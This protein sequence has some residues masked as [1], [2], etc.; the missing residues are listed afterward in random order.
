MGYGMPF[1]SARYV[2]YAL[3]VCVVAVFYTASCCSHRPCYNE[4]TWCR[5]VE[6]SSLTGY[7]S[8]SVTLNSEAHE[9]IT[10]SICYR[11]T[12]FNWWYENPLQTS[13]FKHFDSSFPVKTQKVETLI[14]WHMVDSWL[15]YSGLMKNGVCRSSPHPTPTLHT[16]IHCFKP[17]ICCSRSPWRPRQHVLLVW[18]CLSNHL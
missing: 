2:I 16:Q 10:L 9:I 13:F 3:Y 15:A 12:Y 11:G 17:D 1:M 8:F 7:P 6:Y 5:N 4:T 14:R 18:A